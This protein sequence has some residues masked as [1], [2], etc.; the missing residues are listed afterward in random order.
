MYHYHKLS[1]NDIQKQ[2]R[3]YSGK[4][5]PI[6]LQGILP[7]YEQS[8]QYKKSK[9]SAP[10]TASTSTLESLYTSLLSEIPTTPPPEPLN[11]TSNPI[12]SSPDDCDDHDHIIPLASKVDFAMDLSHYYVYQTNST[13]SFI[14]SIQLCL[15]PNYRLLSNKTDQ[16]LLS[17]RKDISTKAYT[18]METDP[19][20]SQ[21]S[22]KKMAN[23]PMKLFGKNVIEQ[24]P[25]LQK[26]LA[27]Y[28]KINILLYNSI[29]HQ[30]RYLQ[31]PTSHQ[32]TLLFLEHQSKYE[33]VLH[34][35]G[36]SIDDVIAFILHHTQS[37]PVPIHLKPI[38]KYKLKQLQ[39]M[40]T[41]KGIAIIHI[42][43]KRKLKSTLYNEIKNYKYI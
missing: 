27:F 12:Q 43:G 24:D 25:D 28:F 39:D 14:Q 32:Q 9:A 13:N 19:T 2:L 33:P 16:E 10:S 7:R 1:I 26:F 42:D 38:Y 18:A 41:A 31:P 30:Y 35:S 21:A 34:T 4:P 40:A 6:V 3:Q 29:D 11:T 15:D 36:A 37:Y 22:Q 5:K 17:I 8:N 20:F 23:M